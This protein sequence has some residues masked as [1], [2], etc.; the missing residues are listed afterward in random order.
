M[1]VDERRGVNKTKGTPLSGLYGSGPMQGLE[2][3]GAVLRVRED[4]L[5]VGGPMEEFVLR[6][7]VEDSRHALIKPIRVRLNCSVNEKRTGESRKLDAIRDARPG[8]PQ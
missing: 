6:T 5:E 2:V 8:V 4:C 7:W 3:S 1:V